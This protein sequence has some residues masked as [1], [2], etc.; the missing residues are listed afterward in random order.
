[1]KIEWLTPKKNRLRGSAQQNAYLPDKENEDPNAYN[2]CPS[3]AVL[4][5]QGGGT[6]DITKAA[7]SLSSVVPSITTTA[8]PRSK[9]VKPP[10]SPAKKTSPPKQFISRK[11]YQ[12]LKQSA[13]RLQE[14]QSLENPTPEMI[15]RIKLMESR[16]NSAS[17]ASTSKSR[18]PQSSKKKSR[19]NAKR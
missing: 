6:I 4:A 10:S 15:E 11:T 1:M 5:R 18:T 17:S 14:K 3:S 9:A 8:S 13:D 19:S 2:D 12:R 16:K 7:E